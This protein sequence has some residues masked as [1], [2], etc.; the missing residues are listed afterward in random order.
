MRSRALG[1]DY[2]AGAE[3]D[4]Q[5]PYNQTEQPCDA[6]GDMTSESSLAGGLC[7]SCQEIEENDIGFWGEDE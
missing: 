1:W 4:P 2:P 5:A 6:C 3:H 7:G